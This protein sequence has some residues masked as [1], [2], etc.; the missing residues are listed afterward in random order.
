MH[1]FCLGGATL[2]TALGIVNGGLV[3]LLAVVCAQA[4]LAECITSGISFGAWA[5]LALGLWSSL[6]IYGLL[7]F[8]SDPSLIDL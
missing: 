1:W 4:P 5:G 8:F 2:G 6:L 3:A 7:H